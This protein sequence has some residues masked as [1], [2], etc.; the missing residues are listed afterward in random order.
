MS[1]VKR[2]V[3]FFIASAIVLLVAMGA[4][5]WWRAG[6]RA[7]EPIYIAYIGG[8][9]GRV[10]D[11]GTA[12]RDGVLLAVEEVNREGGIH[13]RRVRLLVGDDAQ[14]PQ[15]ARQAMKQLLDQRPAAVIGHVTSAMQMATIDL[16]NTYRVLTISP[17]T[18]TGALSGREDFFF[19]VYPDNTAHARMMARNLWERRGYRRVALVYDLGNRDYTVTFAQAFKQDWFARGGKVAGE[20]TFTSGTD[21]SF[22]A[23]AR[24]ATAEPVDGIIVLANAMD[25]A[26]FCQQLRKLG[27]KTPV[28]GGEWATTEEL[29][30]Y[31]GKAV[32]GAFFYRTFDLAGTFPRYQTFLKAFEE[33]FGRRP[34][35]PAIHAYNAA[36]VV[37]TALRADARPE[38]LPDT[39]RRIGVFDGLQGPLNIDRY[40][41]MTGNFFQV[42][43]AE[44]RF[45]PVKE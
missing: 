34:S 3:Y 44:G 45:V 30:S 41:D 7:P 42:E 15:V 9:T 17:T 2:R 39:I 18:S 5:L 38:A 36:W 25:T 1:G 4:G 22:M 6:R 28:T 10:A 8:L 13:G 37:F 32:E 20:W 35:Y 26:L 31:G 21:E 23:L 19:R 14:D 24:N 29:I 33:R 12:G 43:V 40:G 27:L 11:M 16:T